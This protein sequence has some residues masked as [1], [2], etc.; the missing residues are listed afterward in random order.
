MPLPLSGE[1]SIRDINLEISSTQPEVTRDLDSAAAIFDLDIDPTNYSDSIPGI[2]MDEFYSQSLSDLTVDPNSFQFPTSSLLTKVFDYTSRD[3]QISVT[4]NRAWISV[5][6]IGTS[7]P[8][9]SFTVTVQDNS[10]VGAPARSGSVTVTNN[11]T[12]VIVPITQNA[13]ATPEID[14]DP[15]ILEID[16]LT[17]SVTYQVFILLML[18]KE[19][20]M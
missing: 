16:G 12:T 14:I 7:L 17:T 20:I 13:G 11:S 2:G 18:V 5:S 8:T 4:D 15:N 1:I 10:N 6:N 9:G 19:I 3:G